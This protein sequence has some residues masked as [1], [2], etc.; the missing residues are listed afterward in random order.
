MD[1]SRPNS[2]LSGLIKRDKLIKTLLSGVENKR[3]LADKVSVS[4]ATVDRALRELEELDIV[5]SEG[6]HY[7][8]TQFGYQSFHLYR[9]I[10]NAYEN[11]IQISDILENLSDG[12][13]LSTGAL[14]GGTIV[15]ASISAPN[16]PDNHLASTMENSPKLHFWPPV[17]DRNILSTLHKNT[18]EEEKKCII[19]LDERLVER[20]WVKE[21]DLWKPLVNSSKSTVF[22]MP[23]KPPFALMVSEECMI[24][25]IYDDYGSLTGIIENDSEQAISWAKAR[26]NSAIER[27]NELILRS[28]SSI[29]KATSGESKA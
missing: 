16:G 9:D 10:I 12:T 27:G 25:G 8:L 14:V 29:S 23:N 3:E 21:E 2:I 5:V 20:L 1:K 28:S 15:R 7:Q 22:Q 26:I 6:S 11:I 13:I 4:R 24:I 17:I 18:I 19:F